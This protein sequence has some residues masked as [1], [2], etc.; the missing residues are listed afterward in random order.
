MLTPQFTTLS[1]Q[2]TTTPKK[3]PG[4]PFATRYFLLPGEFFSCPLEVQKSEMIPGPGK[5]KCFPPQGESDSLRLGHSEQPG[6]PAEPLLAAAVAGP[7]FMVKLI[8]ATA[9]LGPPS[10]ACTFTGSPGCME[11]GPA[12]VM[13]TARRSSALR[14]TVEL[15][16]P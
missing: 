12:A 16:I 7:A 6:R 2:L 10:V 4:R 13:G 14:C 3:L 8:T 9:R 11:A 5:Q 15:G 1:T